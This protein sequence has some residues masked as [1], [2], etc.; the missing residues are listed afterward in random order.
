[1]ASRRL[2]RP[3]LRDRRA[4]RALPGAV[5]PRSAGGAARMKPG[6]F[7]GLFLV[8]GFCGLVY[9]VV[10]L[11]IAM[12]QFGVTTPMV[13]I[14]LSVFMAGLALGSWGAGRIARRLRGSRP[15]TLLRLYAAAELVIATSAT[16]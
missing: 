6:T 10:W 7:F 16:A 3:Q 4:V 11:R 14:V 13:S 9:Q 5:A 1:L 12:A 2:P 8:S 15:A